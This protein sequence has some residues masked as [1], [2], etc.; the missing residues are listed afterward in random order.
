VIGSVVFVGVFTIEGWLRPGYDPAS[1]Y[2]SALSMGPR[3]GVQI[4]SFMVTGLLIV[5][6]ARGVA[7]AFGRTAP[8]GAGLLAL[9]GIGLF[10]SGPFV[11]DP[12]T[13]PFLQMSVHGKLHALFGAMVF[14]LAPASCFVF[15]A[16]FGKDP[17]WRAFRWWTLAAGIVVVVGICLLKAAG[18]PL[19]A[20]VLHP[21]RGAI[22]RAT[23]IPFFAWVFAFGLAMLGRARREA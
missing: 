8:I 9:I 1:L 19:P 2:I 10:A 23:L 15:F 3:G 20:N 14:S 4:A 11:M 16:R 13:V 17:A 5:L 18:L 7:A 12:E 21:W 6:F 22:Q